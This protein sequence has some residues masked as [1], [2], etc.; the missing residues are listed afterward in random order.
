MV[1]GFWEAPVPPARCAVGLRHGGPEDA[2]LPLIS[3]RSRGG[4]GSTN[5]KGP[6]L[7]EGAGFGG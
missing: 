3:G 5:F 2:R 6:G 4:G 7:P 1:K